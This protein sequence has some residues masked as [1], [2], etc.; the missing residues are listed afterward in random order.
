MSY[1]QNDGQAAGYYNQGQPQYQPQYQQP[2]QQQ[3]QQQPYQQQP[4]GQQYGG[5]PPQ[6]YGPA[7][8]HDFDPN[9][10]NPAF[11]QVFKVDKPK[12]N[13]LWAGILFII[14][15]LGFAAVSGLA[16][17]GVGEQPPSEPPSDLGS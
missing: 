1:P 16:I 9:G 7:K 8:Q 14:N 2:M 5:P 13:D 4:G 3:Q 17:R 12:Y 10:G 6:Y 15:F 11:G